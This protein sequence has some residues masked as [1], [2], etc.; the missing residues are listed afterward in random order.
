MPKLFRLIQAKANE[1]EMYKDV[2]KLLIRSQKKANYESTCRGHFRLGVEHYTHF[3]S[4]IRIYS[5]LVLHRILKA[6]ITKNNKL[7]SYLQSNLE[8]ICEQINENEK[9]TDRV[10]WEFIDRKFARWA[11]EKVG[12]IFSAVVVE[13]ERNTM[14]KLE[15]GAR[16]FLNSSDVNLLERVNVIIIESDIA[17]AKIY[18]KVVKNV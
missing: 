15:N 17:S 14:A 12:E 10:A 6:T 13:N 9:R 4:P 18:A 5:D 3:T 11:Y 2:D 16:V 8:E 1:I 7:K